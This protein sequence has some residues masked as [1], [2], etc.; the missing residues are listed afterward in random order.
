VG[1]IGTDTTLEVAGFAYIDDCSR[2]VEVL[3]DTRI[4]RNG[5]ELER[6]AVDVFIDGL[7]DQW[8]GQVKRC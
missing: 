2:L 7:V 4:L 6:N 3:I 1:K 8:E 5:L